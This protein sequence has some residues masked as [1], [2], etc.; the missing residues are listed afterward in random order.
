MAVG[1]GGAVGREPSWQ[2]WC[3]FSLAYVLVFA[4][5]FSVVGN[6]GI[7][8]RQRSLMFPLLFVLIAAYP[9]RTSGP[10]RTDP[11]PVEA[12]GAEQP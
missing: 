4:W 6:F 10:A 11:V 2:R 3:R 5:A 1:G 12:A 9:S 7:L 8:A